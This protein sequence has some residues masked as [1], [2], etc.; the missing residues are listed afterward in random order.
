MIVSVI[1]SIL[2]QNLLWNQTGVIIAGAG[3]S[4]LASNQFR[5]PSCIYI[6]ANDTFYICDQNNERIQMWA[7]GATNVSTVIDTSV[8]DDRPVALTFDK[9]GYLY[10][11]S[12]NKDRVLRY[13]PNFNNYTIVV[14]LNGISS[15]LNGLNYPIGLDLDDNFNL[16]IADSRNDRVV[17]WASN[18]TNATI[19]ID[20]TSTP[21]FYGLLLSP[22]S[23]DAVYLS[24]ENDNSVYLWTFGASNPS[25]T[26]TQVNNTNPTLHRPSGIKLDLD[27][28]LYVAD[29]YNGRVVMYCVNT[30]LG[31]VV[32]GDSGS[33]P[34]LR[35]PVDVGLDSNLNLY[36]VDRLDDV[37]VKYDRL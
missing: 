28:N 8:E 2:G 18:T 14:G 21:R 12:S 22:Y 29:R 4:A 1:V 15:P 31:K 35:H 16:Y 3:P 6:D 27:G 33:T 30:T 36:V 23:S 20:P 24:S 25:V 19:V 34:T 26:L 10:M 7:R 5:S 13:T 17:K 11:S 37:V 9:N 32:V